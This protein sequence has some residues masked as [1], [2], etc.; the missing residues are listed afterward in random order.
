MSIPTLT[1]ND[2][3]TIPAI[4]FGTF[5]LRGDDAHPR[6]PRSVRATACSTRH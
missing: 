4:G 1:L 6:F 3:R 2:G 5:P